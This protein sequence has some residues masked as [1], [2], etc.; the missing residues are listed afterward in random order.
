MADVSFQITE[1][2]LNSSVGT[3]VYLF[4]KRQTPNL[5]LNLKLIPDGVN[6]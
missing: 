6:I 4:R 3:T 1:G 2:N 5:K